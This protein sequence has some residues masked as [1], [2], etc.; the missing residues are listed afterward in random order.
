MDLRVCGG[1][2]VRYTFCVIS[3]PLQHRRKPNSCEVLQKYSVAYL[4]TKNYCFSRLSGRLPTGVSLRPRSNTEFPDTPPF[5]V[6]H[7]VLLSVVLQSVQFLHL[8]AEESPPFRR[9]LLVDFLFIRRPAIF[10]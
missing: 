6:T 8:L 5:I 3:F 1:S 10:Y 2:E 9:F 7:F 4:T